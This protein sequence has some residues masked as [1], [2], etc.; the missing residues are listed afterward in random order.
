MLLSHRT[1]VIATG[2][3]IV[4]LSLRAG[5]DSPG[6]ARKAIQAAYDH[7]SDALNKKDAAGA[8][9]MC[10]PDFVSVDM[11]GTQSTAAQNREMLKMMFNMAK[12]IKLTQSVQNIALKGSQAQ[13]TSS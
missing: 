12:S 3:M 11:K 5:A 13:V 10:S 4:A 7:Q 1:L 8:F 2:C 6:D 9:A